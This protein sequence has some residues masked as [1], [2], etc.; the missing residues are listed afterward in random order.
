MISLRL[1]EATDLLG[2]E[3]FVEEAPRVLDLLL[4]CA[5]AAL[6]RDPPVRGGEGSVVEEAPSARRREIELGR[7]RPAFEQAP[8]E[9]DRG[10]DAVDERIPV[11]CVA[12][13][14]GEDVLEA[15]G[16]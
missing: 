7:A 11:L 10:D 12:D 8:V 5:A 14:V 6:L 9:P 15:P 3:A 2:D 1:A 13:R 4:P 16:A